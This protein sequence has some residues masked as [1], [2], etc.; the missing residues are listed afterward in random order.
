MFCNQCGEKLNQDA[1]FCFHC[2]KEVASTEPAPVQAPSVEPKN[3]KRTKGKNLLFGACGIAVGAILLA[4]I[5]L[6]TG[7]FSLGGTATIEG[8]GFATAEDAAKAYLTGL[9]NQDMD[10]MLSTFAVESYAAH[11]DF[12]AL[13]ERLKSYQPNFEMRLPG[14]NEYTQRLNIEGR[15]NQIVNQIIFQ[16]MIYNTPDELNDYS[17]VTFEDA[18]AIAEFMEKFESNTQ[19][20]VFADIEITGTLEPEDISEMYLSETNQQNIAS[21]AKI[22]GADAGDVA[23]VVITFEADGHEWIFCPQAI[24]YDGK[25]YLQS[26]QGN[27]AVLL[28]MTVYTGGIVPVDELNL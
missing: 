7:V 8:T 19:D 23:N 13:V 4:V 25:W 16:Y 2:G 20:Y 24:Q 15:R 11:Y 28:G 22:Y 6:V 3:L 17:P 26:L 27:I 1:R 5:L 12:A 21:Q 10:A 18:A 9:Q 14:T